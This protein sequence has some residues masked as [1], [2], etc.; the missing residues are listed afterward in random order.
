[1]AR[2]KK[3]TRVSKS[4]THHVLDSSTAP[5]P[6]Q[7][8]P[9]SV[10]NCHKSGGTGSEFD[11]VAE[12]AP[13]I[14]EMSQEAQIRQDQAV[15]RVIRR[16]TESILSGETELQCKSVRD[17][18]AAHDLYRLV[19]G[20]SDNQRSSPLVS[21]SLLASGEG[22]MKRIAGSNR[23]NSVIETEDADGETLQIEGDGA[24]CP[25]ST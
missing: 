18:R 8:E 19:T 13:T 15:A 6:N 23:R 3:D 22:Q 17:F 10:V 7:S 25:D 5:A 12:I 24:N 21:I 14:P 9:I 1:M 20:Q 4:S 11:R 2:P 16:M